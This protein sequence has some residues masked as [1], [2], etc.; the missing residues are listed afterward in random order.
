[1][2][3]AELYGE[4]LPRFPSLAAAEEALS[5]YKNETLTAFVREVF[6]G[7]EPS[8]SPSSLKELE[9]WYFNVSCPAIG[10][11]GYLIPHALGFYFGEVL[12]RNAG[13]SWVVQSFP[14]SQGRYEI[15]VSKSR[16]TLMLTQ[17]KRPVLE[18]NARKNSLFR[19]YNKYA[20]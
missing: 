6:A 4:E 5:S 3:A 15:G 20:R 14:F 2:I 9:A 18:R 16:L 19:A 8:F 17:G 12:C 13:F 10:Q 7:R 11:N 1:M